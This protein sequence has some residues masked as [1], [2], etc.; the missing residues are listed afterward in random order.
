MPLFYF[1]ML[2]IKSNSLKINIVLRYHKN[3][4]ENKNATEKRRLAEIGRSPEQ[5]DDDGY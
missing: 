5:N 4:E 3:G 1:S 2:L